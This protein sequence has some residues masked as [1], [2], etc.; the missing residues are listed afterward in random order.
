M[1]KL[2]KSP[3]TA[4]AKMLSFNT[5]QATIKSKSSLSDTL[6]QLRLWE[7]TQR[8]SW[9]RS[10]AGRLVF[11]SQ[12]TPRWAARELSTLLVTLS[13]LR[14]RTASNLK[15]GSLMMIKEPCSQMNSLINLWESIPLVRTE[16]LRCRRHKAPTNGTKTSSW[17]MET[18]STREVLYLR[19]KI[20]SAKKDQA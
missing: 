1:E 13:L 16:L 2:C 7:S 3:M 6:T 11:H 15:A 19:F 14:E 10:S 17:S 9:T 12:S 4:R 18:L 20:T 5:S 8:V